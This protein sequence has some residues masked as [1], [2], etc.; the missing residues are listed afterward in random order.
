MIAALVFFSVDTLAMFLLNGINF[1]S[2]LDIFFH[3]YVMYYLIMGVSSH[4]KLKKMPVSE[5]PVTVN[6]TATDEYGYNTYIEEEKT[7]A[8]ADDAKDE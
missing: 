8:S 5:E 3:A 6:A 4:F 7:T 1:D 2:V